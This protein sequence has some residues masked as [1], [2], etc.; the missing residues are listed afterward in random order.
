MHQQ[1][2]QQSQTPLHQHQSQTPL[3]ASWERFLSMLQWSCQNQDR[4]KFVDELRM[5]AGT[6]DRATVQKLIWEPLKLEK[7]L[8]GALETL[9]TRK[10]VAYFPTLADA[11]SP[12]SS[13]RARNAGSAPIAAQE[14][15]RPHVTQPPWATTTLADVFARSSKILCALNGRVAERD[16][17]SP[18]AS[19]RSTFKSSDLEEDVS[20]TAAPV[21][22]STS[23]RSASAVTRGG[24]QFALSP[25]FLAAS[26]RDAGLVAELLRRTFPPET[27]VVSRSPR[28][29]PRRAGVVTGGPAFRSCKPTFSNSR[30]VVPVKTAGAPRSSGSGVRQELFRRGG[31]TTSTTASI[32][33]PEKNKFLGRTQGRVFAPH[34]RKLFALLEFVVASAAEDDVAAPPLGT[35][36][37]AFLVRTILETFEPGFV[38]GGLRSSFSKKLFHFLL[39]GDGTSSS[40]SGSNSVAPAS[41]ASRLD[42]A[43]AIA[44]TAMR[45]CSRCLGSFGASPTSPT[46]E[47]QQGLF[48]EVL[49]VAADVKSIASAPTKVDAGGQ[50]HNNSPDDH[51]GK[52]GSLVSKDVLWVFLDAEMRQL[53]ALERL[54][55]YTIDSPTSA[56]LGKRSANSFPITEHEVLRAATLL[57]LQKKDG[58]FFAQSAR[59]EDVAADLREIRKHFE[60]Q[61]QEQLNTTPTSPGQEPTGVYADYMHRL[62]LEAEQAATES[63]GM[64]NFVDVEMGKKRKDVLTVETTA[65]P[66]T[67]SGATRTPSSW[68]SWCPSPGSQLST[69]SGEGILDEEGAAGLCHS[70]RGMRLNEDEE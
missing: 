67:P 7:G 33:R 28:G 38:C 62:L 48:S 70:L 65:G 44:N 27:V 32:A 40:S 54:R 12:T 42:I 23:P 15:Q 3:P 5:L 51:V 35:V 66:D 22:S 13:S 63:C 68:S 4:E 9:L 14:Q 29:L 37:A 61:F 60:R 24:T 31:T 58:E 20:S 50:L 39:Y 21:R 53:P 69:P 19:S 26:W 64:E 55:R 1:M 47:Q 36:S 56:P 34:W 6:S 2:H 18:S 59:V 10:Y 45:K 49:L 25:M 16:L 43:R 57:D 11:A 17:F 46:K 52:N 30:L 8:V 41:A